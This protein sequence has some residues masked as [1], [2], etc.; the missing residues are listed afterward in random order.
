VAR[1]YYEVLGVR[2]DATDDEIKRAYRRLARE[3]HP[4]ANPDDPDATEKFKEV[5]RA[6]ETLRDPEKRRRYDMFGPDGERIAEG[7][8][9]VFTDDV[10]AGG[11]GDLFDAFFGASP[12]GSGRRRARTGPPRGADLEVELVLD[13]EEAVFGT[14]RDVT[15]RAPSAC[16]ACGGSG[17]LAGT[18]PVR[19]G[20]CNGAGEVRRVRQSLLGQMITTA[21][22]DRCG[23]TGEEVLSPCRECRGEGRVLVDRTYTVE[24]PAGID[25][26]QTLRLTGRGAAGPRGGQPGDLYVHVRVRPHERFT[27]DG[28]DLVCVLHLPV[29]QAALGAV[30]EFETL[31]GV[32]PL[33][34]PAG[35]QTG[36]IFRLR[37][38][39]VPHVDGRGRGDL[40]V[41][42][43]VDTPTDLTPSQQELLRRLAE[44]RGEAVAPP[45]TGFLSRIRSAFR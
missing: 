10:F 14:R 39:G 3:L 23:G 25:D 22:C 4:D 1:D 41:K 42:V 17:A 37:G 19:C 20:L 38:R 12:F 16:A 9:G 26:G 40:H 21:V 34:I 43:V 35:T 24:V 6:Y 7:R 32:E 29:T 45:E 18:T 5:Q 13:F 11:L 44:E 33:V 30:L 15:V 31:D 2:R 8:G 28:Y 27:R 36:R